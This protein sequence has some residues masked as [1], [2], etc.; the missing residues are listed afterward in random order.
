MELDS[1]V[2][3]LIVLNTKTDTSH[4]LYIKHPLKC[5]SFTQKI[6]FQSKYQNAQHAPSNLHHPAF[7]LA[8]FLV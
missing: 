6:H 3:T 5:P 2:A 7:N 8:Q 4:S 1:G